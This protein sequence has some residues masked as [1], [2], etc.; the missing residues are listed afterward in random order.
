MADKH[1]PRFTV[2]V[3]GPAVGPGRLAVR[4]VAEIARRLEQAL[5]RVGQV[6]YGEES[7]GKG[8][9]RRDIER[10]CSLYLV[11]W[12][13]GS[14]IAGFELAQPPPQLSLFGYIG[15]N[16]LNVFF[17]GLARLSEEQPEGAQLPPGFD[18]GVLETC[19]SLA[20]VLDRGID[21]LTFSSPAYAHGRPVGFT[22]STRGRVL[23]LLRGPLELGRTSKVGRLEVLNGHRALTGRLWE[24]DGTRWDC[25]FK[26]EHQERLADG[27]LKT[28]TVAGQATLAEEGHGG[29]MEVETILIHDMD[30]EARFGEPEEAPFWT[31][32][33]LDELA[34]Q[35]QVSAITD[36]TALT[37][38]WP[39]DEL[40][41]DD[42]LADILDDRKARRRVAAEKV[43]NR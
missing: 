21:E 19:E 16:S 36:L 29:S 37:A 5:K 34:E 31:A 25:T 1:A 13:A 20:A 11:S 2:K 3:A 33:S 7:R 35:Q 10:L 23:S 27:W 12:K 28:V 38:A 41:E 40:I 8:R 32:K 26:P 15:E 17:E 30:A 39:E 14:A 4:D 9:K 6:L 24:P 18:T 43:A 22:A 42:P